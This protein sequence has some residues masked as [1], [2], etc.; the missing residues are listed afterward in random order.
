M[1][2]KSCNK[3]SPRSEAGYDDADDQE[4]GQLPL[5]LLN[6]HANVNGSGALAVVVPASYEGCNSPPLGAEP[7]G[8]GNSERG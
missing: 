3:L 7:A 4:I 1:K 8:K 2:Y 5:N 6:T